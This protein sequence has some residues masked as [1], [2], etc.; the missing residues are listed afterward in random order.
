MKF[1]LIKRQNRPH[2]QGKKTFAQCFSGSRGPS[3]W[4]DPADPFFSPMHMDHL[5]R[6][7]RSTQP[8]YF[9]DFAPSGGYTATQRRVP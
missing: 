8:T 5:H 1:G 6:A 2:I 3:P 7:A 4:I 9:D